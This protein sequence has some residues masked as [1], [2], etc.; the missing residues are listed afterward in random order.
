MLMN[1]TT[2]PFVFGYGRICTQ[3]ISHETLPAKMANCG[4][5]YLQRDTA[6]LVGYP[7]ICIRLSVTG[8]VCL[9]HQFYYH[10]ILLNTAY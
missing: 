7:K 4:G 3:I 2:K 8:G 9:E 1:S 5:T 10:Q 6:E